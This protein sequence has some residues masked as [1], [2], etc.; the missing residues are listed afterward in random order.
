MP[1]SLHIETFCLGDWMTNCFVLH[2]GGPACWFVDAGFGPGA[3][4]DY[5]RREHLVPEAVLL[6]HAH[7][8]HI[9]GL[10]EIRESWPHLPILIHEAEESFLT[11]PARNLSLVLAEQVIAPQATGNLEH[12]HSIEVDGCAFEL[13]HCPGHSPGGIVLHHAAGNV[14]I[15]GDTLFA[16]SVGRTDFPA[17]NSELLIQSIRAQLL[18]LPD[19]TRLLPGHGPQTTV[20]QER[21]ENPFL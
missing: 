17:S 5:V 6:T 2:A 7:V 14:A 10:Q 4:T 21:A 9:A 19:S 20:G 11:H 15:V 13:R 8:D 1:S 18:T 3:M 16:G 12:G